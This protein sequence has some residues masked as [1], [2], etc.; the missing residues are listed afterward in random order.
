MKAHLSKIALRSAPASSTASVLGGLNAAA[1]TY[2]TV[3][4][5]A[6]A[7]LPV[8]ALP[9][10]LALRAAVDHRIGDAPFFDGAVL[11][12]PVSLR[13]YRPERFTGQTASLASAELRARLFDVS[14]Y[15]LPLEVGVL[16]FADAGR[17]WSP[18]ATGADEGGLHTGFGGGL[19]LGVLDRAVVNVTVG[20]SSEATLLTLGAGFAY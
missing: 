10:T 1:S 13:G 17:V 19:W 18:Q 20:A 3:G 7:Y 15:I 2:G 6:A 5:E 12:G 16:G 14:T 8:G 11:G 4:G 9:L